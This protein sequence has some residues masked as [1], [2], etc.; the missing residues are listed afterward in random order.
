VWTPAAR[1]TAALRRHFRRHRDQYRYGERVR[2]LVLRA[3]ADSLLAPYAAAQGASAAAGRFGPAA[4][5]SL[6]T[7]DTVMVSDRSAEVYRKVL[8]AKDRTTIGPFLHQDGSLLLYRDTRLAPRP[9]TFAEARSSVV[10]DYQEQ[11]EDQVLR[12]LRRRYDAETYPDR[13]RRAADE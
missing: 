9:K 4:N 2:T 10:R 12:R 5:D 6:V 1:D 3:P 11:Y 8:D 13:L 7:L